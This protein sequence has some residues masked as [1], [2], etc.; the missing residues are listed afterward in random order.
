M[1]SVTSNAVANL[2]KIKNLIVNSDLDVWTYFSDTVS[3]KVNGVL[4]IDYENSTIFNNLFGNFVYSIGNDTNIVLGQFY[5]LYTRRCFL[6]Q[7]NIYLREVTM[8]ELTQ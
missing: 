7:L 2:N 1:Q 4:I 6:I 8:I 3:S 5:T